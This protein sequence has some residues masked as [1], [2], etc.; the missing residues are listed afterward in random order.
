[1]TRMGQ[2]KSLPPP[3]PPLPPPSSITYSLP[4][5]LP[6]S[7]PPL[8]SLTHSSFPSLTHSSFPYSL[9]PSLPHP[10]SSCL[11]CPFLTTLPY[12]LPLSPFSLPREMVAYKEGDQ[13]FHSKLLTF[14]RKDPFELE[15]YYASPES[16]P[17]AH[18]DIGMRKQDFFFTKFKQK[19]FCFRYFRYQE[20]PRY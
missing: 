18:T 4:S 14:Y 17:I 12:S 3:P 5:L 8:P 9:P 1:M 16:L 13:I 7:V 2:F 6:Y 15:A 10:L 19:L 11:P 20:R